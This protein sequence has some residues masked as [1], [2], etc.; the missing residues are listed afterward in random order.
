VGDTNGL[1][2]VLVVLLCYATGISCTM[3]VDIGDLSA[4]FISDILCLGVWVVT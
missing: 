1:P 2:L 3:G 4:A